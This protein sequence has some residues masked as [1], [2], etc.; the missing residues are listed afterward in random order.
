MFILRDLL[1]PLQAAFP[2]SRRG[3]Q[4][5]RWFLYTLLAV[6]V[7]FTGSCSSQLLRALT[8][9]FGLRLSARQFYRFM[10]SRRMPWRRLWPLLWEAIPEPVTHGRLVVAL[11]DCIN[12]KTGRKIFGCARIFDHA[13]KANQSRWPWAQ[14]LVVVGLL[15]SIH[16]RWACLPLAVRWYLPCR[17]IQAGA[18]TTQIDG[19]PVAFQTKLTQAA[20]MLTEIGE[21]FG[22]APLLA[23]TDS[24]FGNAGLWRPMRRSLGERFALLSRRKRPFRTV[25]APTRAI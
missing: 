17:T 8:T 24:W 20:T 21:H 1:P 10:A 9:L 13:A 3:Q 4:R 15:R 7:P 23:V 2:H 19:Q 16:G 18:E 11:D 14:N 5:A 12:P 6:I 25:I 22:K